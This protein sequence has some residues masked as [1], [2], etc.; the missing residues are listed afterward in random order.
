MR[1]ALITA[2]FTTAAL[3][4]QSFTDIKFEGLTQ[5]SEEVAFETLNLD[6]TNEVD[7]EQIN[8]AIKNFY[9]F[10]YF[11]DIWVT[12]EKNIL[13]FHFKEKPFIAKINMT[14]YKN[15]EEEL[16]AL[17]SA[18]D[19]NKGTMYTEQKIQSAK[20]VLLS[21][22][23]REGY[24]NSVVETEIEN[25]D[26]DSVVV[27]FNVNKG[28]EIII[29]NISF[30]GASYLDESDFEEIIANKEEDCCFTWFFGQ[31]D[32]EM[33]FEQ[34]EFDAPRIKDLYFQNG[35]LDVKVSPAF[36][37]VDFNNNTA[38]IEYTIDEG[39]QYKVND[40]IIYVDETILDV[41]TIYEDL[42]LEKGDIFDISDLRKDQ[43]LIKTKV[44]D[45]GYAFA[46]IRYDIKKNNEDNTVDIVFNSIAG[47]KVYINDV[48]I[49]GN[50]RT[51]DRVIRRNVYLAPS[52][53][54]T[55]TD[56]KDSVNK[57]KR[58]G[59][60]ED[61]KIEQKR[62]SSD[63]MDLIVTVKEAPTGNIIL[64]GGYGSY[65]GFMVNASIN[66]KNIFGSGLNLG[67]S[68]DY[69]SR[70]TNYDISL[71]NPAIYDSKYSG[72]ATI[73]NRE[74][75]I[76]DADNIVD[77]DKTTMETGLS[78]G[79]GRAIGRYTR[80]GAAYEFET[81]DVD[82][83]INTS[84]NTD[85]IVSAI[86]PYINFN[87]T[88]DYYLPRTGMDTGTSLKYA[89]VGGDAKYMLSNTYFKYF[90]S[91]EKLTDWDIIFR[92]KNNLK[93]LEDTGY[94]P[95]DTTFYMGGPRSL[96][97]YE[98]YAFQPDDDDKPFKRYFTNSAELSFPLI[99]SAKMRFAVFYD[100]GMIGEESFSDVQRS[101]TGG[102]ITWVS[103]F[104]PV[105]FIFGHA[106]DDK[107]GD[108][109]SSFEFNL[110]GKF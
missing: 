107:P 79:V 16:D 109:T 40:I 92:Y 77:N 4:S 34:L 93:L 41:N 27:T 105:Q 108:K 9:N 36:S 31:N 72:S 58:T 7:D 57:L 21:S 91:L 63:K 71:A 101:S 1:K 54:Y 95:Q 46:Q 61:V 29:K 98:S 55:L 104:G 44:A 39:K 70:K 18:M 74:T 48:I 22:L 2:L 86:T 11:K 37:K 67:F 33:N 26:Q 14:G 15:R 100:Y 12:N 84:S 13:T 88:D 19:I 89:G 90:H 73:Y 45:K 52:D 76:E 82:Y 66:D 83:K 5:I 20:D 94:I 64:G 56:Y 80:A 99:P 87:N 62:V 51:L 85:F 110:G 96:R 47:D 38:N 75:I 97:G 25:L 50:S 10:K 78:L 49:S 6:N 35:F 30:K 53:Q 65:D 28:D 42:K 69:S 68:V 8:K 23:E 59:Y 43:E 3:S 102:I 24:I 103:P 106:L 60:F 17:Y 81:V 32:G